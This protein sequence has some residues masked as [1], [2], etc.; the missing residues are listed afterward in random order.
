VPGLPVELQTELSLFNDVIVR[1]AIRHRSTML[2]L[3]A[4]LTEAGDYSPISPIE[5]SAAGGEK[6]AGRLVSLIAGQAT[7]NPN[8]TVYW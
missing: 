7:Q 8:C 3:R 2:D 6:L 4:V 5:P 1:E